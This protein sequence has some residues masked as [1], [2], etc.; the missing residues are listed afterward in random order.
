MAMSLALPGLEVQAAASQGDM[1]LSAYVFGLFQTARQSRRPLVDQW[2][3]NYLALHCKNFWGNRVQGYPSP[4][5]PEMW[6]IVAA[7]VGWMTDTRPGY[8]VAPVMEAGASGGTK[9]FYD[10]MAQDL[11][12]VL[13]ANW[14]IND[15]DAELETMLWDAHSY[16]TGFL[17]TLWDAN[18]CG[19]IGDAVTRR[20]DPFTFYPDPNASRMDNM[21][22]CIEVRQM[23]L[24][25]VDR[26]FPGKLNQ[27]LN[28]SRDGIDKAPDTLDVSTM[29]GPLLNYGPVPPATSTQY[30]LTADRS[31]SR[32]PYD[33]VTVLECWVRQHERIEHTRPDGSTTHVTFDGWRCIIATSSAILL[34]KY[35]TE[36]YPHGQHPYARFVLQE[37]GEFWGQSL[38][39]LLTPIQSSI[40]WIA[41]SMEHHLYLTGN[42][43]MIQDE[44]SGLKG[45]AITNAP[46]QRHTINDGGQVAWLNP[47]S[48][49][50]NLA[51][52]LI[53]FY[54]S[55]M[56]GVSGM[57]AIVRG[58]MPSG[59]NAEGVLE[60]V[61][62]SAFVRV[63]LALRNLERTLRVCGE[64]MSSIIV[65]FYDEP[66]AIALVGPDGQKSFKAL[67]AKHFF[68][69]GQDGDVPLRY[70]LLTGAGSMLPTSRQARSTLMI[71]LFNI[72]VVD[73]EAVLESLQVPNWRNIVARVR[74]TKAAAGTLGQP[75]GS[76][77]RGKN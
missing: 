16:G 75:P 2:Q 6:P 70:Q 26:T 40:N 33:K 28:A 65:E 73:E 19:G 46:G 34:D 24:Q 67:K 30:G 72:G 8:E 1:A 51:G 22:F 48:M 41:A 54:K 20:V 18:L 42:P 37:T 49:D 7:Q 25:E 35:A 50:A 4:T 56:E 68:L 39:E 10:Q 23:T 76:R 14:I 27:V 17:K 36:M 11:Q 63:R 38:V 74:E 62:E 31:R 55:E 29:S 53:Q 52:Q 61:Q 32:S 77:A 12:T 3:R 9:Y 5:L 59:R 13:H 64:K 66:R 45:K 69:P 15:A 60:Q 57:S 21:N 43:I 44:R 71:Q 58:F 47:P